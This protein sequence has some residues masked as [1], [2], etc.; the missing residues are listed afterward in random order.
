MRLYSQFSN[1]AATSYMPFYDWSEN[2]LP[3]A[4]QFNFLNNNAQL[5]NLLCC[6]YSGVML[7]IQ[8]N[9]YRYTENT[10]ASRY[11]IMLPLSMNL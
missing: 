6:I 8:A 3:S 1:I 10:C 5:Y 4:L 9:T 7:K 2:A 11:S